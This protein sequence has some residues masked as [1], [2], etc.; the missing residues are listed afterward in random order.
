MGK[1]DSDHQKNK[2]PDIQYARHVHFGRKGEICQI[3]R[4]T[5][6]KRTLIHWGYVEI[7]HRYRDNCV[8]FDKTATTI[9][10]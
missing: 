5:E 10:N 9:R 2:I 6:H 7:E 8:N 1:D 4:Q 3:K